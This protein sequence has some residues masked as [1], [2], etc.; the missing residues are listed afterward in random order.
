MFL[1][2]APTAAPSPS[3]LYVHNGFAR[4]KLMANVSS[5]GPSFWGIEPLDAFFTD[6]CLVYIMPTPLIPPLPFSLVLASL[7]ETSIFL[8]TLRSAD[9][10]GELLRQLD[11]ISN[12]GASFFV[13]TNDAIQTH[14]GSFW[15]PGSRGLA[16]LIRM[17]VVRASSRPLYASRMAEPIRNG[18]FTGGLREILSGGRAQTHQSLG[19]IPLTLTAQNGGIYID[20]VARIVAQATS[21]RRLSRSQWRHFLRTPS[22]S[23]PPYHPSLRKTWGARLVQPRLRHRP[24]LRLSRLRRPNPRRAQ[25]RQRRLY[26][27]RDPE[28]LTQPRDHEVLV[29]FMYFQQPSF[30]AFCGRWCDLIILYLDLY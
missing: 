30:W 9:A 11:T 12:P 3:W 17:H 26:L 8:S 24:H 10:T 23:R 7:P 16:E 27:Q 20:G 19:G 2:N 1:G 4:P 15:Q 5:L 18:P 21:L 14:G 25:L 28:V 6:N 29:I 22:P 13:P